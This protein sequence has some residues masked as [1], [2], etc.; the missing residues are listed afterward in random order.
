[1]DTTKKATPLA[2]IDKI[3]KKTHVKKLKHEVWEHC[4]KRKY[5]GTAKECYEEYALE[6]IRFHREKG[7]DLRPQYKT[8]II[9]GFLSHPDANDEWYTLVADADCI[10]EV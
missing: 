7:L 2:S 1:M 10:F 9:N 4:N 8:D 5:A 3:A 6:Y